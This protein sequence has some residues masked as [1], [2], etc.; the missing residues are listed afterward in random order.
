MVPIRPALVRLAAV[1]VV[2]CAAGPV[3]ADGPIPYRLLLEIVWGENVE[4]PNSVTE[5]LTYRVR[6]NISAR[7]C[8]EKMVDSAEDGDLLLRA[9]IEWIRE[10]T[11]HDMSMMEQNA[12]SDP[13]AKAQYTAVFEA[14]IR[15]D[16]YSLPGGELVDSDRFKE[17]RAYRPRHDYED[18]AAR[19]REDAATGVQRSISAKVCG[20]NPKRLEKKIA[21]AKAKAESSG[22]R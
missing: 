12:S 13:S 17:S 1:V 4:G 15:L 9:T 7:Q 20:A 19:A 10:E 6:D 21:K 2:F 16:L 18:A 11:V 14:T 3:S 8:V 5:D 22:S